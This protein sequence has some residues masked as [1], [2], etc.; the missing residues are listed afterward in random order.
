MGKT[1]R[2]KGTKWRLVVEGQGTSLGAYLDPVSPSEATLLEK[3]LATVPVGCAH[4]GGRP[5]KRPERLMP[6]R[7]Y[8]SNEP[9]RQLAKRGI[10]ATIP[11]R[12]SNRRARHQNGRKLRRY[13]HRW[14]VERTIAWLGSFRGFVVS[15]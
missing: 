8:D 11:A 9:R 7:G 13:E 12:E 15:Y 10:E 14:I 5:R 6:D 4:R 3:T 1:K 2:G